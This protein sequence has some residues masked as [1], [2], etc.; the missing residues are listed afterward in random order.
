[1]DAITKKQ[2]GGDETLSPE[3]NEDIQSKLPALQ[4]LINC[5]YNYLTRKEAAELRNNRY[6][7]V[8]LDGILV[9]YLREHNTIHFK[10]ETHQFS[11]NNIINAVQA[12]KDI[13]FDGLVRTNEKIFEL[14][15]LGKSLQQSIDGD[16]K[17][18]TLHY[19][20]W[21]N[22]GNNVFHVTEEF[23][24]ERSGSRQTRRPD[25]VL[26]VNGI[27]LVVIE[28]K[29]PHLKDPMHEAISQH[30]HNQKE[31]E[32]PKLY[33][34]SQ[35]LLALSQNEALYATTGTPEKF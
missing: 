23:V 1:M 31:D 35:L 25:I 29:S 11:E 16:I 24:V 21:E 8:I 33:L 2:A 15:C 19:I 20:D 10:N 30:I 4:L 18:F 34:Y 9:P 22:P 32:I 6:N 17:S 28:N 14:L 7:Q 27:P 13:V 3:I 12:L 5:G 26:F